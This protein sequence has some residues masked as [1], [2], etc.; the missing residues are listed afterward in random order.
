MLQGV[1]T[2]F[3]GAETHDDPLNVDVANQYMH[4]GPEAFVA[5]AKAWVQEFGHP[6][7]GGSAAPAPEPEVD[8]N[9]CPACTFINAAGWTHCEM[10]GTANPNA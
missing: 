5:K 1:L 2:L 4:E 6:V 8:L 9:A 7:S 10:C 3:N